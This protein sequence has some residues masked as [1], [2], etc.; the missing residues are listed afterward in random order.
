MKPSLAAHVS[1]LCRELVQARNDLPEFSAR[2]E[3]MIVVLKEHVALLRTI[4]RR[5]VH[6]K[7]IYVH[8]GG[9][10]TIQ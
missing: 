10:N 9:E 3:E 8:R 5:R 4:E 7:P 1:N 2:T 6:N